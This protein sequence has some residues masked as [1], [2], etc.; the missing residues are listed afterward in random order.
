MDA[1][2]SPDKSV[3][4]D[5]FQKAQYAIV[6]PDMKKAGFIISGKYGRGYALLA[7]RFQVTLRVTTSPA[8]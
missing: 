6:I 5:L 1:G 3:P 8:S 4:N 7:W 2:R